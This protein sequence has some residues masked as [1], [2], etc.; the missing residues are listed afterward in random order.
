MTPTTSSLASFNLKSLCPTGIA[1]L[2]RPRSSTSGTRTR[3]SGNSPTS[4]SKSRRIRLVAAHCVSV[5]IVSSSPMLTTW[6]MTKTTRRRTRCSSARPHRNRALRTLSKALARARTEFDSSINTTTS[7]VCG[8]QCPSTTTIASM[9]KTIVRASRRAKSPCLCPLRLACIIII[10]CT[11]NVRR[12]HHHRSSVFRLRRCLK[13]RRW[14][15]VA[16]KDVDTRI[17][18]RTTRRSQLP[19]TVKRVHFLRSSPPKPT[20]KKTTWCRDC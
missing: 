4:P 7:T 5:T 6:S 9:S 12:C 20:C 14:M 3:S 18:L 1:F 15:A 17:R 13:M 8:D 19:N 16:L 11:M 10:I 2:P